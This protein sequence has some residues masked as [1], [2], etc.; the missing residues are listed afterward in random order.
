M[1]Q[2]EVRQGIPQVDVEVMYT[3]FKVGAPKACIIHKPWRDRPDGYG[4]NHLPRAVY[5]RSLYHKAVP[6]ESF[7]HFLGGGPQGGSCRYWFQS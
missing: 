5:D 7:E 3:P 2:E 1:Y 6:N 4:L